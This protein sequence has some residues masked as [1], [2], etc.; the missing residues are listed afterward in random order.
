MK[1]KKEHKRIRVLDD[2]RFYS[3][4]ELDA[5][6]YFHGTGF[7]KKHQNPEVKPNIFDTRQTFLLK[8]H[9]PILRNNFLNIF[10]RINNQLEKEK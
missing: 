2:K 5:I 9:D 10:N 4:E 3:K 1:R 6:N 7:Y 8:M